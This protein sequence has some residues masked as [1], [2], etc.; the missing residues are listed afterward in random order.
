MSE[1]L[2]VG[3][4][5]DASPGS[6]RAAPDTATYNSSSSEDG[7]TPVDTAADAAAAAATAPVERRKP[8]V[9]FCSR[10]HS[11]LSQF[12]GELHRTR[13]GGSVLLVAVASRKALCVNDEVSWHAQLTS[14]CWRAPQWSTAEQGCA[15]ALLG[16]CE[17]CIKAW[18]SV[19]VVQSQCCLPD[20]SSK[21]IVALLLPKGMP[22]AN[23]M[24]CVDL[25]P[26][27]VAAC[28]TVCPPLTACLCRCGSCQSCL[29]STSAA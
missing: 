20:C 1:F 11:Q 27:K 8:Q 2:P 17:H 13:F 14:S 22:D 5:D 6:K 15:P 12:V 19:F 25:K 18:H 4:A 3:A 16:A 9:I 26:S 28:A 7:A 24:K 21:H 10:T 29:K 23:I